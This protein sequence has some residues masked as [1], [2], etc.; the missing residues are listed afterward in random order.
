MTMEKETTA[1]RLRAQIKAFD[2][3]L[4][5]H[6]DDGGARENKRQLEA[7]LAQIEQRQRE[8]DR[9]T[10]ADQRERDARLKAAD[11]ALQAEL[12][13]RE[14]RHEEREAQRATE[15]E[16]QLRK[17]YTDAAPGPVSDGDWSKIRA[18]IL[19]EFR[20]RRMNEHERLVAEQ[21]GNAS[22]QF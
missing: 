9:A 14:R 8:F 5:M 22:Y 13:E 1:D 19:H 20:L 2:H 7:T 16:A 4:T 6:P 11:K 12:A 21:R 17:Q 18:E 15:L 10:A 3:Q